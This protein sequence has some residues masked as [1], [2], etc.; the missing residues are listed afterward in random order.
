MA[1]A[2]RNILIRNIR[3]RKGIREGTGKMAEETRGIDL[4]EPFSIFHKMEERVEEG[5]EFMYLKQD[6]EKE[7]REKEDRLINEEIEILR[8]TI[9]KGGSDK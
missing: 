4:K 6:K 5:T 9:K 1:K 3:L 7:A 8:K 2:K